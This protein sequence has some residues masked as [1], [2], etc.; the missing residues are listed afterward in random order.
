M[1]GSRWTWIRRLPVFEGLNNE[2]SN[3]DF[4]I[5]TL[6]NNREGF[7]EESSCFSNNPNMGLRDQDVAVAR[8][9]ETTARMG[10]RT[11]AAGARR[12]TM[13]LPPA[14]DGRGRACRR[15]QARRGR[16]AAGARRPAARAVSRVRRCCCCSPSSIPGAHGL[17]DRV[18]KT[19]AKMHGTERRPGSSYDGTERSYLWARWS[20]QR[21]CFLRKISMEAPIETKRKPS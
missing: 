12:E 21:H 5:R 15:R 9:H 17:K 13:G 18:T 1:S 8:D 10:A 2:A 16:S 20:R 19:Q 4:K 6:L 14:P 3:L 11:L 7:A